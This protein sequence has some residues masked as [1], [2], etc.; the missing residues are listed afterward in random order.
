MEFDVRRARVTSL[1][2]NHTETVSTEHEYKLV[3]LGSSTEHQSMSNYLI[4]GINCLILD[5]GQ[6]KSI[7]LH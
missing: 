5:D 3:C 7:L 4:M 6:P 2:P 1:L